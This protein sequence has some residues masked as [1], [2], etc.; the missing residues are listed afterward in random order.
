MVARNLVE[1]HLARGADAHLVASVSAAGDNSGATPVLPIM[2]GSASNALTA[3]F[4][5]VV[6]GRLIGRRPSLARAYTGLESLTG[7]DVV[8]VHGRPEGVRSAPRDAVRVLYLHNDAARFYSKRELRTLSNHIDLVISVSQSLAEQ[9]PRE[10]RAPHAVV[11]NG[12]DLNRFAPVARAE[13]PRVPTVLYVG[14]VIPQKG[15]H[16]LIEAA[17]QLRHLP[18][19]LQIVGAG[20][21]NERLSSYE[22]R[23]RRMAE[24]NNL[25]DRINFQRALPRSV[26]PHVMAHSDILTVPSIWPDPCPLVVLEGLAS[27]VP[28]L[29]SRT[30]GIPE[31]GADACR[32]HQPGDV[33][34]LALQLEHLLATPDL[35]TEM[36]LSARHRALQLSWAAAESRL[37]SAIDTVA[38][39]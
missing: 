11:L 20:S 4:L 18:F 28:L 32:Y 23:L 27:G 6:E 38:R 21:G 9:M 29:A 5:G 24:G 8:I 15:V 10:L 31:L 16:T 17:I 36:S 39:S 26:I 35:R 34:D 14:R 19:R 2:R 22:R 3:R 1:A 25:G 13:A 30:G 37:V 33:D 12:V 7:Q